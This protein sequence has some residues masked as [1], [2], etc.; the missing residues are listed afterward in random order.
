VPITRHH[1]TCTVIADRLA[2]RLLLRIHAQLAVPGSMLACRLARY[3]CTFGSLTARRLAHCLGQCLACCRLAVGG[4][5]GY[6]CA[7]RNTERKRREGLGYFKYPRN[8]RQQKD[9]NILISHVYISES[10]FLRP[11]TDLRCAQ[12]S[13]AALGRPDT[14]TRPP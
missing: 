5:W 9:W 7:V 8:A 1:A 13:L 2:A 10:R 4:T 11:H 3:S 14:V 12:H 6:F